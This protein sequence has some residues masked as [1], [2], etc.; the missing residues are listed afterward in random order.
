MRLIFIN[1]FVSHSGQH[2]L[3]CWITAE[4]QNLRWTPGNGVRKDLQIHLVCCFTF[5]YHPSSVLL[6]VSHLSL[7]Q[8]FIPVFLFLVE[9]G[10]VVCCWYL[11]P[12]NKPPWFCCSI[13]SLKHLRIVKFAALWWL[14]HKLPASP[15]PGQ[16]RKMN[17]LLLGPKINLSDCEHN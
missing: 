2:L 6:L 7:F 11:F 5:K 14:Y 8:E 15:S 3:C 1:I 17:I 4:K 9:S 13:S 12:W 10:L 16:G